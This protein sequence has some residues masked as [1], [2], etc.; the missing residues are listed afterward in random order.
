MTNHCERAF[1]RTRLFGLQRLSIGHQLSSASHADS[2][3]GAAAPALPL[4][5]GAELRSAQILRLTLGRT[6]DQSTRERSR[7]DQI[8]RP[9]RTSLRSLIVVRQSSG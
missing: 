6:N 7:R 1:A 2:Q 8:I 4:N 5:G 3:G 9:P